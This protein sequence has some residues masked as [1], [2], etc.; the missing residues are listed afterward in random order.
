LLTAPA[1]R[2][3]GPLINGLTPRAFFEKFVADIFTH[4]SEPPSVAMRRYAT[5]NSVNVADGQPVTLD[6]QERG[7][8]APGGRR[9]VGGGSPLQ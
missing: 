7:D 1:V 8:G 4:P 9:G 3:E 2:A 5:A 6:E